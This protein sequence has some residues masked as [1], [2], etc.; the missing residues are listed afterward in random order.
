MRFSEK[1]RVTT[2]SFNK[3]CSVPSNFHRIFSAVVVILLLQ[4]IMKK[5]GRTFASQSVPVSSS[6]VWML[7]MQLG[8]VIQEGKGNHCSN[9]KMVD[10]VLCMLHLHVSRTGIVTLGEIH[11]TADSTLCTCLCLLICQVSFLSCSQTDANV[12]E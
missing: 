7:L 4:I 9:H 6:L 3:S 12:H 1:K 2:L 5:Q 8:F 11:V 10:F